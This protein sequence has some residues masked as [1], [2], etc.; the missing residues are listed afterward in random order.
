MSWKKIMRKWVVLVPF[1]LTFQILG[2]FQGTFTT[3]SGETY[4]GNIGFLGERLFENYFGLDVEGSI[5]SFMYS[6]R[7]IQKIEI[8][9]DPEEISRGPVDDHYIRPTKVILTL[10][11]GE[12]ITGTTQYI[13]TIFLHVNKLEA[14]RYYIGYHFFTKIENE[15]RVDPA[16]VMITSLSV[17]YIP[18]VIE[19]SIGLR[20]KLKNDRSILLRQPHP[21]GNI[22]VKIKGSLEGEVINEAEEWFELKLHY[23]GTRYEGWIRIEDVIIPDEPDTASEFESDADTAEANTS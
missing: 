23:D 14:H 16:S 10:N 9:Y 20:V 15:P 18:H 7:N 4:C 22:V 3:L 2:Q 13:Y 5:F 8:T 6:L 1:C 19:S 17:E 12:V 21:Q 11:S